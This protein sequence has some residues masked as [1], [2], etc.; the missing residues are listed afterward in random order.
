[1]AQAPT[2]PKSV[3]DD[4]SLRLVL[5]LALGVLAARVLYLALLC[6]Y[7]LVEDEAQYWLWSRFIDWSYYSKGPGVA[8]SIWLSTKFL[9]DA[10]WAVRLP[11]AVFSAVGAIAAGA[12]V[13][14][15]AAWAIDH[16]RSP[17]QGSQTLASPARAGL[18]AAL[19][20]TVAPALQ[21]TGLLMTIDGPYVACWI[22][23]CWC[24][25]HAAIVGNS[26]AWIGVGLAIAA[27]FLF[28]YTML[29]V[30]P[31]L[32]IWLWR[33]S[34]RTKS[35]WPIAGLS[36]AAACASLGLLPV[37]IWN[38]RRDW[39]T[40]R[41]LMGH[42]GLPG[43][44]VPATA[45]KDPWSPWWSVEF[46]AMQLGMIGPLLVLALVT[47]VVFWRHAARSARTS[48]DIDPR[49]PGQSLLL[50]AGL[51]I[52]LFYVVIALFK[53]AEGNWALGAYATLMPL[54]G[55][56]GA[57][58]IAALRR[59]V[60]EGAPLEPAERRALR[61]RKFFWRIG[62]WYAL[63]AAV[64]IHFLTHIGD[65]ALQLGKSESFRARF[66]SVMHREPR[67]PVG[68]LRGTQTQAQH[69]LEAYRTLE[70][71]GFIIVDHYGKACQLIYTT[72]NEHWNAST[73]TAE[74]SPPIICAMSTIGGRKSQFD[75][76]S[77]NALDRPDL[78]GKDA[79]IVGTIEPWALDR[80]RPMFATIDPASVQ[81]LRGDHR[82][83]RGIAIARDFRLPQEPPAAA[84]PEQGRQ[85]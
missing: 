40:V 19:A 47:G 73:T 33:H 5:V 79:V 25:W 43:G 54:A 66:K 55:W 56:L 59:H 26:R 21:M 11:T 65:I 8:W 85:P 30:V 53:E 69:V 49:W 9:G 81:P 67:D 77:W 14:D 34:R 35:P 63:V 41:H 20:Y 48:L 16:A 68:R 76:W 50:A 23:C 80:F 36:V 64:P 84:T 10:E 42:L 82:P 45:P 32:L 74:N 15:M 31:G 29:L 58:A 13:R 27:G 72:R 52:L 6:R 7:D 12:L 38:A 61:T 44:D 57:D 78:L 17:A 24:F 22:A 71:P 37:I 70:P 62:L 2:P 3:T 28:K 75:Y 60:R 83:N 1:M 4:R 51:P 18:L 46:I 39:P